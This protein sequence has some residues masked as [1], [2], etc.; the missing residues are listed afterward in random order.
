MAV[1][2]K[3]A[4]RRTRAELPPGELID[5]T[6]GDKTVW[7]DK[8]QG[9]KK[10]TSRR[11]GRQGRHRF[12]AEDGR[13]QLRQLQRSLV[14]R[15][16]VEKLLRQHRSGESEAHGQVQALSPQGRQYGEVQR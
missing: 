4:R 15:T 1:R 2:Q 6:V 7:I 9:G 12:L 11:N 8:K 14:A 13:M 3:F 10:F 16:Q 5:H